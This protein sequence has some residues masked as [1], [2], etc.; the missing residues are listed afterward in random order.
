L[1]KSKEWGQVA[2]PDFEKWVAAWQ[3]QKLKKWSG[4]ARQ[5]CHLRHRL[6]NPNEFYF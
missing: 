5:I 1:K 3:N 2:F 4:A 6:K